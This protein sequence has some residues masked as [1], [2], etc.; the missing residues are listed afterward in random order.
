MKHI[1]FSFVDIMPTKRK[2]K[3]ETRSIDLGLGI[4]QGSSGHII[5]SRPQGSSMRVGILLVVG[6]L[7]IMLVTSGFFVIQSIAN[8]AVWAT[9][10]FFVGVIAFILFYEDNVFPSI[11]SQKMLYAIGGW[12]LAFL[13]VPYVIVLIREFNFGLMI[14]VSVLLVIQF[15]IWMRL[16]TTDERWELFKSNVSTSVKS[17]VKGTMVKGKETLKKPNKNRKIYRK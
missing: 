15:P 8:P 12:F 14:L 3:K 4:G 7:A 13:T 16:F 1:L 6:F 2:T 9:F 10:I 11:S 5:T 17:G